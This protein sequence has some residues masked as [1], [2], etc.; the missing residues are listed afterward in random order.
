[1]PHT[2][3]EQL[4]LESLQ[5]LNLF[6]TE[7]E[8]RFDRLTY[9]AAEYFGV[10]LAGLGLLGEKSIWFKSHIGFTD[11][12]IPREGSL[13][14]TTLDSAL[15]VVEDM[16]AV[17]QFTGP[18]SVAQRL[19]IRFYAA[20]QLL[21]KEGQVAGF[22]AVADH[23]P[24]TFTQEHRIALGVIAR[25][26][27]EELARESEAER[28]QQVA[29]ALAPK[30]NVLV[31]GYEIAGASTSARVVGGD[32]FD[33]QKDVNGG[34]TFTVADVMG[35]GMGAAIIA[36]GLRAVLRYA[37]TERVGATM[38][39][40]AGAIYED[41][42]STGS[43]VTLLHAS[44]DV[45]NDVVHYVDAGHGL[46][47]VV[48]EDGG[49]VRVPTGGPPLGLFRED[50]WERQSVPLGP[51]DTFLVFSDGVLE[52]FDGSLASLYEVARVVSDAGSPE[53]AVQALAGAVDPDD[54]FDDVT[55]VALKRL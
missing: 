30:A 28:A 39:R 53:K 14:E 44:L 32:F 55:V 48:P 15:V 6:G 4:R 45:Q 25:F 40:V 26:L 13:S 9:M 38:Q 2:D 52:L 50:T 20:H 49:V 18:Q 8:T 16:A 3:D 41:L 17:P 34:I 31:P 11:A 37:A 12:E 21:T 27:E 36:A 33:W 29:K 5:A 19:G 42:S 54:L 22:F 1:M 43:F 51:G 24:R 23:V 47:M 35:K 7:V 46:A 10:P